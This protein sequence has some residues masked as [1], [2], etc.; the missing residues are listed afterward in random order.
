MEGVKPPYIILCTH[1]AFVDFK[2]LTKAIF[3]HP[4]NYIVAIDGF[5]KR[6]WLLRNVGGIC[7]R[8]FVNDIKLVKQIKY[9]LE[10]LKSIVAIF[11]EARYSLIGTNAILPES[12]GKMI[13]I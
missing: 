11:P 1:H 4:A 6:E 5:I 12:L 2:V 7:K 8:K 9:S 3:P 13:K 10:E